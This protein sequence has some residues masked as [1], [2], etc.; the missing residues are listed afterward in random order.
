MTTVLGFDNARY[1]QNLLLSLPFREGT[2]AVTRDWSKAYR[3]MTLVNTPPWVH[4][5]NDLTVL[6]F[7][8]VALEELTCPGAS[9]LDLDFTTENFSLLAWAYHNDVGSAHVIMSRGTL[10]TCGWELYTAV[11]NLALRTNQAGSREGASGMNIVTAGT[12]Q[13]LAMVRDGLIGQAYLNG[14]PRYTLQSTNGLL[15]PVACGAQTFQIGNN[16]NTNY[17]DGY[18]WNPRIWSRALT[19]ADVYAI[20]ASERGLFGV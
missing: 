1:N 5:G 12:W 3:E 2:G 20:F 11:G 9:T 16:P 17:F 18:L 14:E 19:K 15:D 6:D 10:D 4:L 8:P 13:C 7:T